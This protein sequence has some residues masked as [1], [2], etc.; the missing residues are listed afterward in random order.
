MQGYWFSFVTESAKQT[1]YSPAQKRLLIPCDRDVS[2]RI[3]DIVPIN[4]EP[5]GQ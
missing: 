1:G 5:K 2:L 3:N 4:V